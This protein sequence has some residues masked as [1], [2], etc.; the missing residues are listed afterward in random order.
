MG[1]LLKVQK[2]DKL[3]TKIVITF[4]ELKLCT[5]DD[6]IIASDVKIWFRAL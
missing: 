5:E 2:I 3:S 6:R 4:A 1:K